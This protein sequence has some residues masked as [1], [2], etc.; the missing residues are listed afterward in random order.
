MKRH[1]ISNKYSKRLFKRTAKKVHRKNL[2]RRL[3]R[4]GY[5]F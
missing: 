3:S 2:P 1:R 5:N 4:G